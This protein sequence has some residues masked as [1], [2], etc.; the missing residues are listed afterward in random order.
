MGDG[1]SRES[2]SPPCSVANHAK[3]PL[4][5]KDG[6]K[7]WNAKMNKSK[8]I[9]KYARIALILHFRFRFVTQFT[10][11]YFV[12]CSEAYG[13]SMNLSSA[14]CLLRMNECQNILTSKRLC[15]NLNEEGGTNDL[16]IAHLWVVQSVFI[17]RLMVFVCT[18]TEVRLLTGESRCK[19]LQPSEDWS[20][21]TAQQKHQSKTAV[22]LPACLL[23]QLSGYLIPETQLFWCWSID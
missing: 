5:W 2:G 11:A 4:K 8:C 15:P 13:L 7:T 18:R 19:F 22:W 6:T 21:N 3:M 12:F 16:F 17:L 9:E 23:V 20:E 1:S 14:H 10:V